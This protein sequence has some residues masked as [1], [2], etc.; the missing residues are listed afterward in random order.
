MESTK[1]NFPHLSDPPQ[2]NFPQPE[3]IVNIPNISF[4]EAKV[5]E[6]KPFPCHI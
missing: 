2:S 5:L 4:A 3:S 1:E 6:D